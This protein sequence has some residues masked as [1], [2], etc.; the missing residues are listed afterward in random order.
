MEAI[1][2]RMNLWSRGPPMDSESRYIQLKPYESLTISYNEWFG[3][4]LFGW[5]LCTD[6]TEGFKIICGKYSTW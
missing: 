2:D 1:K 3:Y 6:Y 4:S 5:F